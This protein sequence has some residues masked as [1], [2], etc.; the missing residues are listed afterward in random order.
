MKKICLTCNFFEYDKKP[1]YSKNGV[2]VCHRYPRIHLSGSNCYYVDVV[3]E[4]ED[5]CGEWAMKLESKE[6]I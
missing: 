5:W 4:N 6:V 1:R 2:G 3:D